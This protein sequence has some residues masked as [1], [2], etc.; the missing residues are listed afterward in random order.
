MAKPR[1]VQEPAVPYTASP[2]KA[3][4]TTAPARKADA[5]NVRYLDDATAEKLTDK[6][7]AQRKNLLR[8]LAQ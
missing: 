6:I 8:K 1:K 3:V 7:F 4:R 5:G 2:K